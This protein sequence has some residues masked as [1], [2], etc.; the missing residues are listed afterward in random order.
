M[1]VPVRV[2]EL[3]HRCDAIRLIEI[4]AASIPAGT[5]A[6]C[7]GFQTERDGPH[8]AG[9]QTADAR[10]VPKSQIMTVATNRADGRPKATTDGYMN[11]GFPVQSGE[12]ESDRPSP[13]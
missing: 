13:R 2:F 4:K 10:S 1:T 7:F 11:D 3:G 8:E 5:V 9:A 12:P 6:S